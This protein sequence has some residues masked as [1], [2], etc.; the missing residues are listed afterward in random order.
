MNLGDNVYGVR[1]TFELQ[2]IW[3]V[4]KAL[5]GGVSYFKKFQK[6]ED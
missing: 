6:V 5:V 1:V 3:P 2:S 4:M